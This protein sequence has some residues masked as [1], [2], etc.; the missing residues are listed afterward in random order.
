[1]TM[2]IAAALVLALLAGCSTTPVSREDA[3]P[4]E[5]HWQETQLARAGT[6]TLVLLRDSGFSGAGC[7]HTI[8]IDGRLAATMRPGE[9]AEFHLD[10]GRYLVAV[11]FGRGMCPNVALSEEVEIAAD[12]TRTYRVL[13]PGDG[14]TRL[15]RVQ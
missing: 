8:K 6:G 2:R 4:S 5:I 1:M 10:P 15:V 7:R 13:L 12:A 11:E 3:A 14:A 9:R